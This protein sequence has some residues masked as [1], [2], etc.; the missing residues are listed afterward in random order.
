MSKKSGALN[1]CKHNKKTDIKKIKAFVQKFSSIPAEKLILVDKNKLPAAI[2]TM[3]MSRLPASHRS[4]LEEALIEKNIQKL[5]EQKEMEK[6]YGRKIYNILLDWFANINVT[7]C[8][9]VNT[10]DIL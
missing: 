8:L 6:R 2:P 10:L 4:Y 9:N 7:K 5:K 3:Y 1:V